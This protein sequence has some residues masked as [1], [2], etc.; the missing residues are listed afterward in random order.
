MQ[1]KIFLVYLL[2]TELPREV[3]FKS[4]VHF[5]ISGKIITSPSSKYLTY[6][7]SAYLCVLVNIGA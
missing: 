7:S 3:Q 5:Q 1:W 6:Y 2:D 4:S